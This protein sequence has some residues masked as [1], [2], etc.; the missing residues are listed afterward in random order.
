MSGS[1]FAPEEEQIVDMGDAPVIYVDGM[2][3]YTE[4]GGIVRTVFYADQP[5][6][7]GTKL[8]TVVLKLIYTT[9]TQEALRRATLNLMSAPMHPSSK[10]RMSACI[11]FGLMFLP[12]LV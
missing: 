11:Q 9:A 5:M 7:D 8:R 6:V 2:A 4:S 10:H 1:Q 12:L 3:R